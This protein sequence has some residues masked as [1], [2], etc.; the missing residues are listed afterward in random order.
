MYNVA[1]LKAVKIPTHPMWDGDQCWFRAVTDVRTSEK[2]Y[3]L[4]EHRVILV[5]KLIAISDAET[6]VDLEVEVVDWTLGAR[7]GSKMYLKEIKES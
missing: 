5:E 7:S 3:L 4:P 6:S 1:I 2:I